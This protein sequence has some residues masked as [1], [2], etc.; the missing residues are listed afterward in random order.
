MIKKTL[1]NKYFIYDYPRIKNF[2]YFIKFIFVKFQNFF[3][4]CCFFLIKRG[5]T[6]KKYNVS[7]CAIFKNEAP[8]LKEWIEYHSLIG[9]DHFYLYNNNSNDN[10]M[11]ILKPYVEKN[12]VTIIDF[13]YEHAQMKAYGN[14]I[15]KYKNESRWIGFID[16][17]EFVVPIKDNDI[18]T[19]LSRFNNKPAV[20]IY[21]KV[22]GTSGKVFRNIEN[23]VVA[24]FTI[25][26]PKYDEVGKCFYN[27]SFDVN[28]ESKKMKG[29][30]HN[31]WGK[32]HHIELPPVNCFGKISQKGFDTVKN[33]EF[34]IQINHY[35][36]KSYEE[37]FNQKAARGDVYFKKNHYVLPSFFYRHEML[38]TKQDNNIYKYLIKLKLNV[39]GNNIANH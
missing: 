37:Y 17:D 26:W 36:T 18:Y 2:R 19:F 30:H 33:G 22:F 25:S 3:Y 15:K 16:I 14:C 28:L 1:E 9:V 8:Y 38:C 11:S 23:L 32:W 35:F 20:K 27:T 7:L 24:D 6:S 4:Y 12:K 39:K 21:W 29:L 10:Y 31:F 13:P 5:G 34:P